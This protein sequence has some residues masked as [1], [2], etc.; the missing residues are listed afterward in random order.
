MRSK[1]Q[2]TFAACVSP[3]VIF[4]SVVNHNLVNILWSVARKLAELGEFS[5][6]RSEN[7][8]QNLLPF[9]LS[10]FGK[11]HLQVAHPNLPQAKM[12]Q[13]HRL[14]NR[15][16]KRPRQRSRQDSQD[17]E[18]RPGRPVFDFPTHRESVTLS[19]ERLSP[20]ETEGSRRRSNL[21]G[22]KSKSDH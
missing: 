6:K 18:E 13:I 12:Q 17:L 15:N 20:N 11:D 9:S 16:G 19:C 7:A 5:P 3:F 1:K 10:F 14:R 4:Q 2:H 8:A 21:L 22:R